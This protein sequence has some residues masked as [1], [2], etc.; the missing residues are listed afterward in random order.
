MV[1]DWDALQ[2]GLRQAITSDMASAWFMYGVL[3][4]LVAFSVL[5]T[6]LMSVLERTREFGVMLSLGMGPGKL[7]RLV[8]METLMMSALGLVLG[9]L[10]GWLL[11][12]YLSFA[13]F[14]FPGHGGDGQ[15]VQSAGAHVSRAQSA[16]TVV[17][18]GDCI[19]VCAAGRA[20]SRAAPVSPAAGG[21]H[22]GGLM[23]W[24]QRRRHGLAWRNLWRNYRRTLIMLAGHYR[25]RLGNDLYGGADAGHDGPDGA[26]TLCI[27]CPAKCS[28]TIATTVV[29]PAWSTDAGTLGPVA[30]SAGRRR[31]VA[32]AARVRVPAVLASERGSRGVTLLGIDPGAEAALGSLPDKSLRGAFSQVSMIAGVVLG[33]SLARRLETRAGQAGGDDVTGSG[34]QCRRPRRPDGGHLQGPPAGHEDVSSTAGLHVSPGHAGYRHDGV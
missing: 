19:P 21:S 34:Q 30:C 11:V 24:L 31:R 2:P 25:G 5:N 16:G 3:I 33:A 22:E 20:V 26:Q 14:Y 32:W 28:Y 12:W 6:Q 15:A 29:T 4:V 27:P 13:G 17:G 10:L 23:R 1:L 18:P 9:V 8:G 7:A